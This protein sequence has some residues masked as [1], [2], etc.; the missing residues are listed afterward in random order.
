MQAAGEK[1]APSLS[2]C[3][4][5][6]ERRKSKYL[7]LLSIPQLPS[8]QQTVKHLPSNSHGA[9]KAFYLTSPTTVI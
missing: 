9:I 3:L 7:V 6:C 2:Q 4:H 8:P 1:T 5:R